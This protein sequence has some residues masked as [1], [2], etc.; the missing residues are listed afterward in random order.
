[1]AMPP[2]LPYF[3]RDPHT[4]KG[5]AAMCGCA[6]TPCVPRSPPQA[7]RG[8]FGPRAQRSIQPVFANVQ[9]TEPPNVFNEH[10]ANTDVHASHCTR[11]SD[12][13]ASI[14]HATIRLMSVDQLRPLC[15]AP[16]SRPPARILS[17]IPCRSSS[18]SSCILHITSY[19][20]SN[21]P[22]RAMKNK[23]TSAA[24]IF[25]GSLFTG[26][27][28]GGATTSKPSEG[29]RRSSCSSVGSC[30]TL[31]EVS[32]AATVSAVPPLMKPTARFCVGIP[33]DEQ[34]L[35]LPTKHCVTVDARSF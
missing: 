26:V 27:V 21:G 7:A 24:D 18:S 25:N 14:D 10:R 3:V 19:A 20:W 30:V 8:K 16:S 23:S 9:N 11:K 5:S 12:V 31:V 1:M 33:K 28:D 29:S 32:A 34:A 15:C 17:A 35:E 6:R 2:H 22:T 13:S 4:L